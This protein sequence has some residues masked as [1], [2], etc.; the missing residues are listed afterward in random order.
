MAT[1]HGCTTASLTAMTY[2]IWW[3]RNR[4]GV[5][6]VVTSCAPDVLLVQETPKAVL[7]W[8]W[9][10]ERLAKEWGLRRVVGGR[11]AGSNMICVSPRV[12]VLETSAQ[13]VPQPLFQ[14]RRGIA[15]AQCVVDGL[16]FGVVCAHL[17]MLAQSRPVEAMRLL[18]AANRLRGPVLLGGDLNERP[19]RPAWAVLREAGFVDHARADDMTY[20]SVDPRRRIDA[21]LV[22]G[23]GAERVA[24]PELPSDLDATASDH[25]PVMATLFD[26]GDSPLH[27]SDESKSAEG[28]SRDGTSAR[29]PSRAARG[30]DRRR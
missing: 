7:V 26:V 4:A 11:D 5:A 25:L 18:A 20:S 29:A 10:C 1:D 3:P 8:R 6:E 22:R 17:S 30:R 27:R 2:N 12:R 13:R 15:T 16:E 14:P 24:V 28:V 19:G 21:L 9:Q 23:F